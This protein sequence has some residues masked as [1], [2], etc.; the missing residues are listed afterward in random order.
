MKLASDAVRFL[1]PAVVLLSLLI[2]AWLFTSL[3]LLVYLI[4]AVIVFTLFIL[5]FFRDPSRIPPDKPDVIISPADG[6]VICVDDRIPAY[7]KGFKRRIS[8]FLSM[9]D[10]HINRIPV[11]GQVGRIEYHPG[12]FKPAFSEKAY[13]ENEHTVIEI[14]NSRGRIV[15]CQRAGMIARRIVC[16]LK[17]GQTVKAGE[18]FGLIRFGSRV[19]LYLPDNVRILTEIGTRVLAGESVLGEFVVDES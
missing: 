5:F 3:D 4:L 19:D 10:V 14:D 11:D 16:N 13:E 7:I 2:L 9:L 6:K 1:I 18:R 17:T 15:L 8:I 12:K